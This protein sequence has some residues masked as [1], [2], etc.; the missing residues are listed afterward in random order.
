MTSVSR[1][2]KRLA[3]RYLQPRSI[4]AL[5]LLGFA[6]VTAPLVAAIISAS[7][8]V[9]GLARR[10]KASV[11]EAELASRHSRALLENLTAME[12]SLGQY[13]VLGDDALYKTYLARRS[14]FLDATAALAGLPLDEGHYAQLKVLL[15]EET[16]LFENTASL[17][18]EA[19]EVAAVTEAFGPLADRA[20]T[21]LSHSRNLIEREAN[22]AIAAA[23]NIKRLMLIQALAVIPAAMALTALF[24]ILITRPMWEL[25]RAIRRLGSGDFDHPIQVRGPRDLAEL[26]AALDW[27]RQRIMALEDQ[28]TSFLR[29]ISHELKTPLTAVREG[30]ELLLDESTGDVGREGRQIAEIMQDSALHLQK[31]IEN[32]L[33]FARTQSPIADSATSEPV[34]LRAVTTQVLHEHGLALGSKAIEVDAELAQVIVPGD[35]EQL[36][37]IVDNL[38]S[39]AIKFSPASARL[40]VRLLAQ[41]GHAILHV[42][43]AGPGVD[44]QDRA[45]IF[46]PFFQGRRTPESYVRGSGLGLAITREYIEKHHGVIEIVDSKHGAHFKVSLPLDQPA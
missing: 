8:Q 30:V 40:G 26:G 15:A 24:A 36:R 17:T 29:H 38:V 3:A 23:N 7:L 10:S 37:I 41:E 27:L 16:A 21:I 25:D 35:P 46:E 31:L 28:K 12:R 14:S 19:A 22:N 1:R 44:P 43:D 20:R 42:E 39:N 2:V 5:V 45:R 18:S 34:D 11:F 13:L 4:A 33:H 6:L 9:D 32:L